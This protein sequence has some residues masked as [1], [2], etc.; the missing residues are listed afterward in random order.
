MM[1]LQMELE[2]PIGLGSTKM[3][4]LERFK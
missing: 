4:P 3:P 1:S 2:S